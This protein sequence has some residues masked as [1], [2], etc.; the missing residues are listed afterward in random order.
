M[1]APLGGSPGLDQLGLI[2]VMTQGA[3]AVRQAAASKF[4]DL[5]NLDAA[6][7]EHSY[8]SMFGDDSEADSR[9]N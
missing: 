8:D 2:L 5:H 4:A 9:A 6:P 3:A 1:P 7:V